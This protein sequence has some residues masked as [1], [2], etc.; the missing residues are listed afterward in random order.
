VWDAPSHE[1]KYRSIEDMPGELTVKD[2]TGTR[3]ILKRIEVDDSN[4][5]PTLGVRLTMT[6]DLTDQL[7]HLA[8][9]AE[10]FAFQL[11]QTMADKKTVFYPYQSS[12]MKTIEYPLTATTFT[13]A[14]WNSIMAPVMKTVLQKSGFS[15]TFPRDKFFGPV[16]YQG[17][18]C[19]HPY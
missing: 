16:K 19:K 1:F 3:R 12:F 14:Q 5:Q 4:D 7:Y 13:E 10:T 18:G 15:A 6:G 9:E 2:D 8:Q 11:Q 17:F